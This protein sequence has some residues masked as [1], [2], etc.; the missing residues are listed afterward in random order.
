MKENTVF[1]S[2]FMVSY[3]CPFFAFSVSVTGNRKKSE[4]SEHIKDDIRW[5]RPMA[6]ASHKEQ[7]IWRSPCCVYF[8]KQCK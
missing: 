1:L 3:T 7:T 8:F 4:I 6:K 2:I 5:C